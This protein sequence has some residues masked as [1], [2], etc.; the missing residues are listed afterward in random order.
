MKFREIYNPKHV[1]EGFFETYFIR[2]Y[3]HHYADFSGKESMTS[4][5]R[6]LLAWLIVSMGVAGIMM[7][8]I[9]L[10]GPE[11]GKT[12]AVV[13]CSIWAAASVVPLLALVTRASHGG[14][15]KPLRPKL[16]GVDTLLGVSCLLFFLL[17]LLMMTTTLNSG[18]LN[19]NA[20][21]TE[22]TED[23]VAA[24]QETVVEEPIFTYQDKA[25]DTATHVEDTVSIG[26]NGEELAT[27]EESFDPTIETPAEVIIDQP[28]ADSL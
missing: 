24:E 2:P 13:V 18:S 11:A 25:P 28:A 14:P 27:P 7:G 4:C 10:I 20:T 8:Q 16:L 12:A 21:Y 22:E 26:E 5:W 19:P 1:Y 6:S 15:Q 23:S 17:G 9:G 3:F